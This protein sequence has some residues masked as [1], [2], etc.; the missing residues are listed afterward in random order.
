MNNTSQKPIS[1]TVPLVTQGESECVQASAS[2]ILA[3]YGVKKTIEEIK[4]EVPCMLPIL[5]FL[6]DD[7]HLSREWN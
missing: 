1:Y 4:K 2:Q 5:K 7:G 6:I 3:Y